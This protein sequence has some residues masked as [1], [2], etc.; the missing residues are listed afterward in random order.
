MRDNK[1]VSNDLREKSKHL[2]SQIPLNLWHKSTYGYFEPPREPNRFAVACSGGA[3][4][5]FAL[6]ITY[7]LLGPKIKVLHLIMDCVDP[8]LMKTKNLFF[9]SQA[10]SA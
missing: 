10:Q 1:G 3:D 5:I 6:L 7:A 9:Q 4:S 8:T 2:L